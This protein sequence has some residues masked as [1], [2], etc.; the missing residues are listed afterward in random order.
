[1]DNNMYKLDIIWLEFL[2]YNAH[3]H[4]VQALHSINTP[5][6]HV[7]RRVSR[8]QT[9]KTSPSFHRSYR[10]QNTN[11]DLR[12][13]KTTLCNGSKPTTALFYYGPL[14]YLRK[15]YVFT[16]VCLSTGGEVYPPLGRHPLRQTPSL[17]HRQ[18][19]PQGKHP[20]PP[21]ADGHCSGRYASY[22]NAFLLK[23]KKI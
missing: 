6:A 2:P 17:G 5:L 23:R 13:K 10:L 15:G 11:E 1:M 12:H 4:N 19:T 8:V 18:T 14:L 16:G 20:P 21:P 3:C 7:K 22:W 9:T